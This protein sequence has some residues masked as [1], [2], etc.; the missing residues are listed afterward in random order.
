MLQNKTKKDLCKEN[1]ERSSKTSENSLYLF[2]T[3]YQFDFNQ[4]Y[5][6][7]ERLIVSNKKQPSLDRKTAYILIADRSQGS[8][9]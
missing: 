3:V 8:R 1:K 6:L 9:H 2:G 5:T 4:K 7:C